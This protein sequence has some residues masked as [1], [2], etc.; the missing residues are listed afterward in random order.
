MNNWGCGVGTWVG[1]MDAG[2]WEAGSGKTGGTDCFALPA[3]TG[4]ALSLRY[5]Q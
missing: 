3:M 5:L 2:R 4:V 1:E